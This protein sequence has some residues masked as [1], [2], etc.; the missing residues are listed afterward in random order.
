MPKYCCFCS[1]NSHLSTDWC[2]FITIILSPGNSVPKSGSIAPQ[3]GKC[4]DWKQQNCLEVF[5]FLFVHYVIECWCTT[6]QQKHL[7]KPWLSKLNDFSLCLASS[8]VMISIKSVSRGHWWCL[9][10]RWWNTR[11]SDIRADS[12]HKHHGKSCRYLSV[13]CI[14]AFH[15]YLCMIYCRKANSCVRCRRTKR[16][17]VS[18]QLNL[19]S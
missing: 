11:W 9:W 16:I 17:R 8:R 1:A 13:G 18:P 12:Q 5:Y 3:C 6:V 15:V 2:R 4:G 10:L 19:G 7:Q 14:G